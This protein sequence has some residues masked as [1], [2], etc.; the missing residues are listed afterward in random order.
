M[1]VPE[2]TIPIHNR[3]LQSLPADESERVFSHLE[4]VS[5]EHGQALHEAEEA[6]REVYFVNEGIV[7][8]LALLS[9]GSTIEIG[10]VG[11]EGLSDTSALLGA[12]VTPH[13][14]L[15]QIPGHA[16][17]MRIELFKE[18]VKRCGH[19]QTL[20]LRYA[21]LLIAQIGQVAACNSLHTIEERL[22]RWLL[23]CSYRTRSDE[24]PLTQEFLSHMLGVRRAGVTV[25]ARTLQTAG[26]IK[27][28]RGHITILDS[29][30]L[31]SAA[32]ECYQNM[33]EDLT[34]FLES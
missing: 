25:A 16:F 23:L 26:L 7:S 11:Y 10:V 13:Q 27:Y 22:A 31:E 28:N 8:I 21:S 12:E 4:L 1:S 24:L 34:K 9:D 2:P 3:I 17:R 20:L 14:S 19:F 6:I 15:V 18:E 32:C 5:L 30:G 29:E 33:M